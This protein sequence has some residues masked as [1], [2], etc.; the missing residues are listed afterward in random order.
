MLVDPCRE[1]DLKQSEVRKWIDQFVDRVDRYVRWYNECRIK[2]SLGGLSPHRFRQALKVAAQFSPR[3][4]PYLFPMHFWSA[5][6]TLSFVL[7]TNWE[8]AKKT[9]TWRNPQFGARNRTGVEV[10]AGSGYE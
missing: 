3:K 5:V 2:L 9:A 1:N 6:Y 10:E 4:R 8:S 7:R